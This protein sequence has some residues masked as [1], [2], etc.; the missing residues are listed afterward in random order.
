MA[1]YTV[2]AVVISYGASAVIAG[3]VEFL[4]SNVEE[5]VFKLVGFREQKSTRQAKHE[6]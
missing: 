4:L 6:E 3:F 1:V 2:A 5:A